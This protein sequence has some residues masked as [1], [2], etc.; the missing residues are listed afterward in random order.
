MPKPQVNSKAFCV[1]RP[2]SFTSGFQS[3]LSSFLPLAVMCL[4]YTNQPK[5]LSALKT[6]ISVPASSP[7]S[8]MWR[9]LQLRGIQVDDNIYLC[10]LR[11]AFPGFSPQPSS[12]I[13]G[14]LPVIGLINLIKHGLCV[15]L[16]LQLSD[17]TSKQIFP[18]H[19]HTLLLGH[20]AFL[21]NISENLTPPC[22][23]HTQN[24]GLWQ[25]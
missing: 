4:H 17:L 1:L 3:S 18:R 19:T 25:T 12:S 10:F 2:S 16:L 13:L 20:M 9:S 7:F 22:F 8:P 14:S 5:L 15:P 23:F 11:P 21:W 6:R 24:S